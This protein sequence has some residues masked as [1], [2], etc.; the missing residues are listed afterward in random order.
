MLMISQPYSCK[1]WQ[2]PNNNNKNPRNTASEASVDHGN[3]IME[4]FTNNGSALTA[5]LRDRI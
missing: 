2:K 5:P 1:S 3:H 4:Q